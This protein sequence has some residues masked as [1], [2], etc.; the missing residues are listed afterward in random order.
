MHNDSED[1]TIPPQDAVTAFLDELPL[2]YLELD[3]N[4]VITCANRVAR[5]MHPTEQGSLI[6]MLAWEAMPTDEQQQSYAAYLS[7]IESGAEPGPVQ[8]NVYV[9]SGE[10]RVFEMHRRMIRNDEGKSVG[11]RI[12]SLDVTEWACKMEEMRRENRWLECSLESAP[13]A[14]IISD[15]MGFIQRFNPSAEALLGWTAAEVVGQLIEEAVRVIAY[16]S[17]EGDEFSHAITVERRTHGIGT[18]LRKN[19]QQLRLLI[20]TSPIIDTNG[21]A[22]GVVKSLHALNDSEN[23]G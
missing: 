1:K 20:N 15:T 8:R 3:S 14:V 16:S 18:V 5:A 23:N 9:N 7:L 22:I 10:F 6:G 12:L 2:P 4:G 17:P 19:G 21:T 11:M 13:E